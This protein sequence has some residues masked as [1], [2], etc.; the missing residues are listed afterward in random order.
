MPDTTGKPM[1]HRLPSTLFA[2]G[3][4]FTSAASATQVINI[5][6][7]GG[8]LFN[9]GA[10]NVSTFSGSIRLESAGA[11]PQGAGQF[12]G[13]IR[14]IQL[15]LN[16]VTTTTVS[17]AN[18]PATINSYTQTKSVGVNPVDSI[19]LDYVGDFVD[20]NPLDEIV[21][22]SA[23]IRW[24]STFNIFP[25]VNDL[26]GALQPGQRFSGLD[27]IG[28]SAD[29]DFLRIALFYE[30]AAGP[31]D[32]TI[33]NAGDFDTFTLS[34][35]E[36]VPVPLPTAMLLSLAVLGISGM[37]SIRPETLPALPIT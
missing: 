11:S 21:Q 3:L 16:G 8:N 32:A 26:F 1:L 31:V 20:D 22:L 34:V 28:T 12:N 15:T 37:R 7:A 17:L 24:D 5:E 14:D 33:L 30:N 18:A 2:T 23:D 6:F 4:L 27:A 25:D 36:V 19:L 13:V 9:Q 29:F 35:S 10:F